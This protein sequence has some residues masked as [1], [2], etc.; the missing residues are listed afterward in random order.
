MTTWYALRDSI[1]L[2]MASGAASASGSAPPDDGT[3]THGSEITSDNVGPRGGLITSPLSDTQRVTD[4]WIAA[5]NGGS[6]VISGKIFQGCGFNF[7][8]DAPNRQVTFQDCKFIGVGQADAGVWF[9][10]A[11][12]GNDPASGFSLVVDHC[13]FDGNN[14]VT[15]AVGETVFQGPHQKFTRCEVV[16]LCGITRNGYSDWEVTECFVHSLADVPSGVDPHTGCVHNLHGSNVIVQRSKC[17]TNWPDG[18]EKPNAGATGAIVSLARQDEGQDA[19][20]DNVKFLDNALQ[21]GSYAMYAGADGPFTLTNFTASGNIFYR[22]VNAKSGAFGP[23][24]SFDNSGVESSNA[25]SNNTWGPLA[26][27]NL[28]GDPAEGTPISAA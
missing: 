12:G 1:W 21:G 15:N 25:W 18:T 2:S 22:D 23:V 20:S 9:N 17:F 24:T 27:H 26:S 6:Y 14:E 13:Y 4:A 5:N 19:N 3:I 28:G 16:N 10:S 11:L 7:G 8:A